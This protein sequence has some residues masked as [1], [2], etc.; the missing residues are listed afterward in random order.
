MHGKVGESFQERLARKPDTGATERDQLDG[1]AHHSNA[2]RVNPLLAGRQHQAVLKKHKEIRTMGSTGPCDFSSWLDI[3]LKMDMNT[4]LNT[5]SQKACD[6]LGPFVRT[7]ST[8]HS[9]ALFNGNER[10]VRPAR[11]DNEN[12]MRT[13]CGLQARSEVQSPG[14][15]CGRGSRTAARGQAGRATR[16]ERLPP[17][18]RRPRPAASL[19]SAPAEQ[20]GAHAASTRAPAAWQSLA[21]YEPCKSYSAHVN[22]RRTRPWAARGA[23]RTRRAEIRAR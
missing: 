22:A 7:I 10:S 3:S 12:E 8:R 15:P 4:P 9:S 21:A 18:T 1:L 5:K 17:T 14:I 6:W 19:S 13:A 2:C 16:A 23:W 11:R 20:Q